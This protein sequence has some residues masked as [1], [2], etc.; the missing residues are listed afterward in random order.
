MPINLERAQK[1]MSERGLD[2]ILASS[3]DD[4]TVNAGGTEYPRDHP[5]VW[6]EA[7]RGDEHRRLQISARSNVAEEPADV[8]VASPAQDAGQPHS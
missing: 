3:L 4:L 1:I 8:P 2:A 5:V 6:P 7:I